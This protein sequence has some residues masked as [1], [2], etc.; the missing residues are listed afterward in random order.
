MLAF[1]QIMTR[2]MVF[3]DKEYQDECAFFCQ[4]RGINYL[5]HI[6][7]NEKCFYY[8]P[9]TQDFEPRNIERQQVVRPTDQIYAFSLMDRFQKFD[10]LFV[11][12]GGILTGVVHYSDYNRAP[13]YED[14]FKKLFLLEKSLIHLIVEYS[15]L[16]KRALKEF[17]NDSSTE[18]DKQTDLV[19][20]D[21]SGEKMTL[22]T[23]LHFTRKYE[24]VKI[25]NSDIDQIIDLRNKVAHSDQLVS[26]S[27]SN[28]QSYTINTFKRLILGVNS[29]AVALKQVGYRLYFMEASLQ[30]DFSIPV[31]PLEAYL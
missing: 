14:L 28:P 31:K 1:E 10:V 22:K 29:L 23:I 13:V 25:R 11:K 7:R 18:A 20:S 2:E 27:K 8:H 21:F 19:S 30:D 16:K 9:D 12:E 4:A 26:T 15:G 5:P 6:S 17:L 24:L 3:F